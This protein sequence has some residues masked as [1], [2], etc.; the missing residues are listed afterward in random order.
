MYENDEAVKRVRAA[1]DLAHCADIHIKTTAETIFTVEDASKAVG[2][3]PEEILKSL[4]FLVDEKPVL[5]L[6]SGA[7]R[8]NLRAVARAVKGKKAKM[9]EPD[10]VL[11]KFGFQ[12]GGIP[13]IGYPFL[14]PALLDDQ[15]FCFARV[16]AAAGTDHAFFPIEPERLLQLTQGIKA[17]IRKKRECADGIT[18]A[19]V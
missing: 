16:W 5:V 10:Y 4:I 6:M 18:S 19:L 1:L 3:P 2:A 13:P 15:L 8:V 7:N 12:V 14:L 17:E 9:A 11:E